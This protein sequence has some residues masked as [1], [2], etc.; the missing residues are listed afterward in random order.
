MAVKRKST[1]IAQ[2]GLRLPEALRKRIENEAHKHG[3]SLNRELVRRLE[4]SFQQE[5]LSEA[6]RGTAQTSANEVRDIVTL[7]FEKLLLLLGR[8]DLAMQMKKGE[9]DNG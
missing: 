2:I 1:D 9:K 7:Q 3:W 4:S 6:I 8:P 5:L